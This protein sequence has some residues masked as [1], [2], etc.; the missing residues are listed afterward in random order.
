MIN[1]SVFKEKADFIRYLPRI[2]ADTLLFKDLL[3]IME[4][5]WNEDQKSYEEER[6]DGSLAI[7]FVI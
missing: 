4:I 1:A 5:Y 7:S 3:R 2:T 6:D